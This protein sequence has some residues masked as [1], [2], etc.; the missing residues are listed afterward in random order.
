LM[1]GYILGERRLFTEGYRRM[2][3]KAA[4]GITLTLLLIGILTLAFK[5]QPVKAEP[6][7]IT[8]PD[9]YP[10][11]QE[12]INAANPGD[13]IYVRAGT[14]Y[15]H[16]T[17]YKSS[18]KL[19]GENPST[20][21]IDGSGGVEVIILW[22]GTHGQDNVDISGFSV[23]NGY[24]GIVLADADNNKIS[25][26]IISDTFYGI[27][28]F[29]STNNT[30]K[31]NV[32]GSSKNYAIHLGPSGG[33]AIVGN[34]IANNWGGISL[35]GSGS[36]N[37]IIMGNTITGNEAYGII[38]YYANTNTIHGNTVSDTYSMWGEGIEL[39]YSNDNTI[40]HNNFIENKRQ[41]VSY[42]GSVNTWDDGYP[43]GGNYWS[44]YTGLD[45]YS[46]INQDETGEDGI[47]DIPYI[48]DA[49][50]V[51]NYPLMKLY[52]P[53]RILVYT[54][55]TAYHAGDKMQLGL[56]VVNLESPIHACLAVWVELPDTRKHVVLH[57][58]NKG[59][60]EGLD[61]NNPTFKAFTLPS[62]TPGTYVW[63]AALLN[64]TTHEIIVEDKAEWQFN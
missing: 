46:G 49:E 43:S 4:S 56:H 27:A 18:L 64:P 37:N 48:I 14:Y 38:L 6:G 22:N 25:G 33:N 31:E 10:T 3:L 53:Q 51:D 30:I 15:E 2:K 32:I 59:L 45:F 39:G 60:P 52:T 34:T 16:L 8:V 24:Y 5:I 35:S 13:T 42:G 62:L 11:I 55:K 19:I 50:N 28:L 47:G 54:D 7:T 9:D 63:H 26:N 36:D 58:H 57:M 1:L 20:T 40:Y 29:S 23:R 17:V 12:A 44:D 61:Y 41:Q 21:I